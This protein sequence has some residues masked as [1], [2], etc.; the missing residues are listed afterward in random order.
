MRIGEYLTMNG[1]TQRQM[2]EALDVHTLTVNRWANS[3]ALPGRKDMVRIF[4]WTHGAVTPNDFY[5][6]PDLDALQARS[7]PAAPSYNAPLR[8]GSAGPGGESPASHS[9]PGP[10]L[11]AMGAAA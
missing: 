2:A 4:V 1:L 6:L 3:R 11:L 5:D 8:D 7:H 10:L 9:P